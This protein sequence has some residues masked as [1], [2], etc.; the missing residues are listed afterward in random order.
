MR[1]VSVWCGA[2]AYELVAPPGARRPDVCPAC[3]GAP[4]WTRTPPYRVNHNDRRFLHRL[5][6]DPL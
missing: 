2:C 6:I 4:E 5:G 3:G 1:P